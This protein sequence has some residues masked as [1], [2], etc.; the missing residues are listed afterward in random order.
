MTYSRHAGVDAY[1]ATLPSWQARVAQD[2]RDKIHAAP[3]R[4]GNRT[5]FPAR[6]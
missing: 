4:S 2:L 1:Q 5:R 3:W 6:P